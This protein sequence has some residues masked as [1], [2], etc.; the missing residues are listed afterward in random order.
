[1]LMGQWEHKYQPFQLS[2]NF[3]N[4]S[5]GIKYVVV[6]G[7]G[8]NANPEIPITSRLNS[9]SL[10]RLLEG[11]RLTKQM[12][13]AKLVLS[14]GKGINSIPESEVMKQLSI[15]LGKEEKDIIL[16][17]KSFNTYEQSQYLKKRNIYNIRSIE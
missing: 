10:G 5:K 9:H 15:L 8:V 17:T 13:G 2:E 16:E 7:G 6:L 1:M 12:V 3:K 14:G 11:I 4:E